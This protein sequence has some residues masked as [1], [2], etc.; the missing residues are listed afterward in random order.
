MSLVADHEHDVKATPSRDHQPEGLPAASR[1][2]DSGRC[3]SPHESRPI[4]ARVITGPE[5]TDLAEIFRVLGDPTRVRLL[6]ILHAGEQCVCALAGLLGASESAIS[7]QLR[8]LRSLRL[9]RVRRAGRMMFYA[10]D[11]DHIH[12]LFVVGLEHVRERMPVSAR[13]VSG[14][15]PGRQVPRS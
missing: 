1:N 9:V 15:V 6:D 12:Q 8:V 14:V 13:P 5:A 11:D 3:Q 7:H 2:P 10:L 4:P